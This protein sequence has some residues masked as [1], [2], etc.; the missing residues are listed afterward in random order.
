MKLNDIVIVVTGSTRGIG[1]AIAEACGKEGAR[2]VIC[3]RQKSV[4]R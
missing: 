3:C 1:R 2:V 4:V